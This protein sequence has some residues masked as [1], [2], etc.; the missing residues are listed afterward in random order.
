MKS[1]TASINLLIT[2]GLLLA[3][4]LGCSFLRKSSTPSSSGGGSSGSSDYFPLSAG[5]SWK[6]EY[7]APDGKKYELTTR[8][9]N[10]ENESG[11]T[12]YRVETVKTDDW[13]SKP[14][15]SVVLH[16]EQELSFSLDTEF[17]PAKQF[18]K[19][20]LANGDSWHWEGKGMLGA[21]AEEANSVSG[22]ETVTVP[23]GKF[24]AM[25]VT[26]M[27]V[28]A[29]IRETRIKW[30][31]PGVGLVKSM[32]DAGDDKTTTELLEYNVK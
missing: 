14:T 13:Y 5:D 6:Y 3:V 25:K 32:S 8:V 26:T 18:L 4:I 31:A 15:G 24:I 17:K 21:D 7:T 2:L 30:F 1:K 20:P 29:S 27:V 23:A 9:L 12:L 22:P 11:N 16:R 10:E 28:Q 19:N